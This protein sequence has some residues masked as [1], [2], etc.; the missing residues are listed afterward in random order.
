MP[1]SFSSKEEVVRAYKAGFVVFTP[2]FTIPS[3]TNKGDR[4]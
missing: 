3:D 1:E 2:E 4:N